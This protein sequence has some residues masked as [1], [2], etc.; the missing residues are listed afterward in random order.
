M[1]RVVVRAK[2][3]SCRQASAPSSRR[4]L[5]PGS[6][7]PLRLYV[8]IARSGGQG[9]IVGA[10]GYVVRRLAFWLAAIGVL[11]ALGMHVE[12]D[13]SSRP[14][15]TVSGTEAARAEALE[16]KHFGESSTL[17]VLLEGPRQ[18]RLPQARIVARRFGHDRRIAVIGPWSPGAG[19]SLTPGRDKTMLLVRLDADEQTAAQHIVPRLRR[20]LERSTTGPVR[21]YLTSFA[22]IGAGLTRESISALEKGELIA[23]PLLILVL[24]LVF[25]GPVAAAIPLGLGLTTIVASRGLIELISRMTTLDIIA[26]NMASMMGLALGVDYSLV[27]VARFREE[28]ANGI[29]PADAVKTVRHASGHTVVA[30]GLALGLAM[31]AAALTAPGASLG[32]AAVGVLVAAVISVGSAIVAVPAVLALLGERVN[33]W[34]LPTRDRARWTGLLGRIGRRPLVASAAV[35]VAV[36]ALCVP[37]LALSMGSPDPRSL[38]ASSI[39]RRDFEH[40]YDGLGAAWSAPYQIIVATRKGPITDPERLRTLS[41]WQRK[42][43]R[44]PG[45][46]AAT[47]PSEIAARTRK[48]DRVSKLLAQAKPQQRR[49]AHSLGRVDDGV[50]RLRDGLDQA[51]GAARQIQQGGSQGRAAILKLDRGLGL[52]EQ[53]SRRLADGLDEAR[54]GAAALD[55]GTRKART[56]ARQLHAGTGKLVAG[57]QK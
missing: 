15:I 24:L 17:I 26:L 8:C 25:R 54:T 41:A 29:A 5:C 2:P 36:G 46:V 12:R 22:D 56:G 45:V 32:A 1:S 39:E 11:G 50:T 14:G 53:G 44:T 47:G 3:R 23:A 42:L 10:K 57:A 37:A 19:R 48:L 21:S 13:L 52:A 38:P 35:L 28:L 30:A 27:M 4:S 18:E 16:R 20:T 9:G 40:I 55:R 34:T 7:K 43:A 31:I 49:L 6:L 51:A 33:R